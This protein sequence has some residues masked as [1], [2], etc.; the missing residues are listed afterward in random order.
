MR[1]P[2]GGVCCPEGEGRP[3]Q[4]CRSAVAGRGMRGM[5]SRRAGAVL[6]IDPSVSFRPGRTIWNGSDGRWVEI[7]RF[8]CGDGC[9][10]D[11]ESRGLDVS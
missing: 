10:K 11:I 5:D 7:G 1:P 2:S 3:G 4:C 9:E 8:R 6:P